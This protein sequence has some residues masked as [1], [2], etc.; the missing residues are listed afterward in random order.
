M[1]NILIPGFLYWD[2]FKYTTSQITSTL[3]GPA[4]GDL[5]GSYP[6]P[7][8][9]KLQ[10]FAVSS[11]QPTTGQVLEWNGSSWFPSNT[12]S[13]FTPGG[14]L[15]GNSTTQTVIRI[16]GTTVPASP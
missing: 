6:N 3:V 13:V 11:A 5:S 12:S 8:V 9:A 2:G 7:T 16:T 14:D 1:A 10:G 4:T 15:S